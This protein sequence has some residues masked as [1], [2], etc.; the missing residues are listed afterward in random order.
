MRGN[1]GAS[2]D[3]FGDS[4]GGVVRMVICCGIERLTQNL[5][6]LISDTTWRMQK[7]ERG[8]EKAEMD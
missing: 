8:L 2:P 1:I 7:G 4:G 6:F 3:Y 5:A